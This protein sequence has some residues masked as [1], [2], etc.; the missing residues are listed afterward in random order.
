M[1]LLQQFNLNALGYG[2]TMAV[3]DG[4]ILSFLKAYNLGW[5]TWNGII[6]ISMLIYSFQPLI[7]LGS[8][9]NNGLIVMNLLWDVMSDVVVTAVGLYY[10]SEKLSNIK[11]LGV[12]LS[13]IS[14]LLLTWK[15]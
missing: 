15:E 10:F 6:M 1:F 13:F 2:G 11:M 7:F 9:K 14:I 5:I 3:I 12:F 4:V 8:L